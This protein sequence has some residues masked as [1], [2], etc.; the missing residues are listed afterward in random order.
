MLNASDLRQGRRKAT[1]VTL[2]RPVCSTPILGRALGLGRTYITYHAAWCW[3]VQSSRFFSEAVPTRLLP[4]LLMQTNAKQLSD[5][6]GKCEEPVIA[7]VYRIGGL[8]VLIRSGPMP[9][10]RRLCP[11]CARCWFDDAIEARAEGSAKLGFLINN[12]VACK[13]NALI[14]RG[15]PLWPL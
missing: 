4:R 9:P 13:S 10:L 8:G 2:R 6:F 15:Y 1:A 12:Q 14:R 7:I 5:C 11:R 3:Q